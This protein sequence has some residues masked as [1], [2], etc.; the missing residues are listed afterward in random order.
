MLGKVY[1]LST[2]FVVLFPAGTGIRVL[3]DHNEGLRGLKGERVMPSGCDCD[4]ETFG[5]GLIN[6]FRRKSRVFPNGVTEEIFVR[7][8]ENDKW[9]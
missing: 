8:L 5:C 3:N 2:G 4:I 1:T 6:L 9:V 7:K